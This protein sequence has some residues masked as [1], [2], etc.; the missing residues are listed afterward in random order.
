MT[1]IVGFDAPHVLADVLL[2]RDISADASQVGVGLAALGAVLVDE[3]A[4][5]L[6]TRHRIGSKSRQRRVTS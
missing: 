6:V 2:G 1:D 3:R 5:D 4:D